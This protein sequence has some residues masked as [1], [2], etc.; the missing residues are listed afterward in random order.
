MPLIPFPHKTPDANS[1]YR[2]SDLVVCAIIRAAVRSGITRLIISYDIACKY[3]IHFLE[4]VTGGKVRLLPEEFKELPNILWLIGKFHIGGH[5][6]ECL[7]KYSFDYND[8]VGR[9][10]GELVETIW[11]EL[12]WLKQ[13]CR[14]M[15][16]GSRMDLMTEH[17]SHWNFGK[18]VRMGRSAPVL[19]AVPE[20]SD[21]VLEAFY[22]AQ[23]YGKS[24]VQVEDAKLR[25]KEI[26]DAVGSERLALYEADSKK[27]GGEQYLPDSSKI[28]SASATTVST[29]C[30]NGTYPS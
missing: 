9:M 25:L 23:C 5:R 29:C 20:P 18:L 16:P 3:S 8:L 30:L 17:L 2:Y 21:T 1:R 4:R 14:E 19:P 26:V 13:Q 28:Q 27:R 22:L 15:G 7:K 12:N 11:A 6:E 10:S 24:L